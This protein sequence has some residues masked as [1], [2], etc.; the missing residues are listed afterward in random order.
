MREGIV[1]QRIAK[2]YHPPME[3]QS[4]QIQLLRWRYATIHNLYAAPIRGQH[5]LALDPTVPGNIFLAAGDL[6]THS[7]LWDE[8]QPP[9]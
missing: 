9:D 8:H 3:K 1:Y 4:I 7:P 5:T 6:N 2:V